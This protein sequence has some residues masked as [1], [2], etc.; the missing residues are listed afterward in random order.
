[1]IRMNPKV[2][3]LVNFTKMTF[4]TQDAEMLVFE[5]KMLAFDKC[6]EYNGNHIVKMFAECTSDGRWA[7]EWTQIID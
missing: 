4:T 6:V 3:D 5:Y 1:M 2:T 7:A